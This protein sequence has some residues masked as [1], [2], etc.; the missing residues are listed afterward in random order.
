[1][2][3][4]LIVSAL[5]MV[6]VLCTVDSSRAAVSV[7]PD[8]PSI[9]IQDAIILAEQDLKKSDIDLSKHYISQ[10]VYGRLPNEDK[11]CWTIVWSPTPNGKG[12]W[13]HVAVYMDKTTKNWTTK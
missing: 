9:G 1:M 7:L 2:T 5:A 12:G 6:A 8:R 13:H 11:W 10:A 4:V 3:R